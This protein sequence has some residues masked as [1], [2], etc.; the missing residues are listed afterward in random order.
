MEIRPVALI[1]FAVV[2]FTALTDDVSGDFVLR[3]NRCFWHGPKSC[4]LSHVRIAVW[5]QYKPAVQ[6]GI[7]SEERYCYSPVYYMQYALKN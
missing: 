6:L 5:A 1:R 2:R 3:D 4:I 7:S